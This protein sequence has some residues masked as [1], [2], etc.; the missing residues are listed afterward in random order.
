MSEVNIGDEKY[1]LSIFG[2]QIEV[3][4][5]IRDYIK[6]KLYHI[7]HFTDQIIDVVVR[8]EVQKLDHRAEIVMKFSHFKVVVHATTTDLYATLDKTFERLQHKLRRWKSKM[9]EHHAR[10]PVINHIPV[11]VLEQ[12][13]LDEINDQIEEENLKQMEEIMHMPRVGKQKSIPLKTLN[14]NEAIMKM[15]LS[16]DHFMVYRCEESK[17]LRVIYRRRDGSYGII[18]AEERAVS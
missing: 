12:Q 7:E 1:R 15:E 16:R 2:H 8:L 10:K 9:Q 17:Q 5:P 11:E 13:E 18:S 6:K 14:M 4:E 3:T